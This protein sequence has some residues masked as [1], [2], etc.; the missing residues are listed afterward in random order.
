MPA[1]QW[2][3]N[4]RGLRSD[5]LAIATLGIAEIMWEIFK[6]EEAWTG[7]SFATTR[8]LIR[9]TW[10]NYYEPHRRDVWA[11]FRTCAA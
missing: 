11:G 9:N 3:I 7:G 5:Y 6:N 1:A 10:R 4:R 2:H 8:R